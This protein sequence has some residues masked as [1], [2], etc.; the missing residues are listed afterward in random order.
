M[1]TRRDDEHEEDI[2]PRSMLDTLCEGVHQEMRHGHRHR[3]PPPE[4]EA[5][6]A[7]SSLSSSSDGASPWDVARTTA[8][9]EGG[10]HL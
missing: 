5:R 9:T 7:W 10:I 1:E 6:P 8:M 3:R 4:D 2:L